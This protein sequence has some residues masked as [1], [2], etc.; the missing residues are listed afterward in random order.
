MCLRL[1]IQFCSFFC[2]SFFLNINEHVKRTEKRINMRSPHLYTKG[3]ASICVLFLKSL[4]NIGKNPLYICIKHAN[5]NRIVRKETMM[6][7]L[8]KKRKMIML[9]NVSSYY[10]YK[11]SFLY[12]IWLKLTLNMIRINNNEK[13]FNNNVNL[14][15]IRSHIFN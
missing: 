5:A 1:R 8:N 13:K 2:S 10:Y 14:S 3:I 15:L 7:K 11:C 9:K 6:N 4:N 12:I